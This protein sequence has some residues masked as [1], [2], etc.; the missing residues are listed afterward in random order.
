MSALA[1][2]SL[3]HIG[4]RLLG[5]VFGLI[6]FVIL[7]RVYGANGYGVLT[8]A[9]TYV[10]VFAIIVDF[11]LTLTAAQMISE[12]NAPEQKILSALLSL[13]L[14]SAGIFLSLP[15]LLLP[16]FPDSGRLMLLVLISS[17][18]SFFAALGQV[19]VGVYQKRLAMTTVVVAETCNRLLVL[20]VTILAVTFGWSIVA[21]ALGFM[22]GGIIFFLIMILGVQ[23]RVPLTPHIDLTIWGDIIKRSWP[24]GAS[25][26][27]NLLYL[28]GDILF[29]WFFGVS[30]GEIGQ[31]GSAYKVVDVLTMVPVTF[32]GLLLPLLSN[33]WSKSKAEF[34]A[35]LQRGFDTM[36][37]LALPLI[38][39]TI[40][41]GPRLMP[42]VSP[43]L[44]LAGRLLMILGPTAAI[45][46]FGSLFSHVTVSI[47]KQR[48]M[49]F[50]FLFVAV[51]ALVG[52]IGFIPKYGAI[53]AAWTTLISETTIGL[54]AAGVVLF[55]T[56]TKLS[57]SKFMS[58]AGASIAM[59]VA[60]VATQTL[61]PAIAFIIAV[62]VYFV[63]LQLLRGPKVSD[64]K[65]LLLSA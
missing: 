15:L 35:T 21:P 54:I 31:Y 11:G 4:G 6:T 18:S 50:G 3:L 48:A 46:F 42:A 28:K 49:I 26:F 20:L 40:I 52:Y 57:L 53:A 44:V 34:S 25:I 60:L 61:H 24:I 17:V 55:A 62:P 9:L 33:A 19:F 1:R 58:A 51:I 14:I 22:L 39:G 30:D 59:A 41:L 45:V 37:I 47:K 64:L 27:F 16:L 2:N 12:E 29:M 38:P 32:M 56:K 13:R 8:T 36:A 63:A 10:S 7:V 5:T 65:K 43:D 23:R